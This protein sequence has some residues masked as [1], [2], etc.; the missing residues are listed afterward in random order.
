MLHAQATWSG[1]GTDDNWSTGDNWDGIAPIDGDGLIF[2]GATRLVNTNNLT[3]MTSA[4]MR[5][6]TG[7]FK[8][9]GNL[10]A[11][12]QGITNV[13][14]TNNIGLIMNWGG[15][16]WYFDVA[17]GSELIMAG[18]QPSRPAIIPISAAEFTGSRGHTSNRSTTPRLSR[19][20]SIHA[21]PEFRADQTH[22]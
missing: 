22:P 9:Y 6:D 8:L 1:G 3:L 4:W 14:G 11:F 20:T 10:L 7:G 16:S 5:F 12:A 19:I 2:A 18:N 15:A 21:L 13:A 17:A